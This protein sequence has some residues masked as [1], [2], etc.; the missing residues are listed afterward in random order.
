MH[1]FCLI[2]DT[3][4]HASEWNWCVLY[5]NLSELHYSVDCHHVNWN[6]TWIIHCLKISRNE[7]L[8]KLVLWMFT[9][10]QPTLCATEVC[11][12]CWCVPH[13]RKMKIGLSVQPSGRELYFCVLVRLGGSILKGNR[14]QT[15]RSSSCRGVSSS[16]STW[17]QVRDFM[18]VLCIIDG[19][20]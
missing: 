20:N 9:G 15:S 18:K 5:K 14:W 13:M 4:L 2:N 11:W 8:Q 6:F 7:Y 19:R 10:C 12:Q 17:A 1:S 16:S 3:A